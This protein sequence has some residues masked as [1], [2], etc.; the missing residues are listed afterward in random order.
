MSGKGLAQSREASSAVELCAS[1]LVWTMDW[2]SL[3]MLGGCRER[4]AEVGLSPFGI[5]EFQNG[6]GVAFVF[7]FEPNKGGYQLRKGLSPRYS[8]G[9]RYHKVEKTW[10]ALQACLFAFSPLA[11]WFEKSSGRPGEKPPVGLL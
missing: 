5:L 6:I 1:R 4:K 9:W 2:S 10:F 11:A 8:R 7:P 3:K